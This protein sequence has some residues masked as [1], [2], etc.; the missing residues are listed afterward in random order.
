MR[1][2]AVLFFFSFLLFSTSLLAQPAND[3]CVNAIELTE[4]SGWCSGPRAFSTIGAS[5]SPVA[6]P[7]CFPTTQTSQD[8]WFTFVSQATDINISVIGNIRVNSG[9][10]LNS[11]QLVLY[12]GDCGTLT[13]I[14]CKSDAFN[15]N[16]VETF[17]GP[18]N[19][20]ERY[21][22]R[23]GA[24]ASNVGTF[25]LC[26]N[27]FNN[28]PEP[29]GDCNTGV[30][31]CDKSPFT[32]SFF[33]GTGF[34]PN[35]IQNSSC[36]SPTCLMEESSSTWYK[37]TCRDPGSLTFRL[38]PLNPSDDLDFLVYELPGGLD[39]CNNKQDIRCMAS[40]EV[41]GEPLSVWQP[42]TGPTGLALNDTDITEFCGCD[43]GDNNFL[44]AIDMVAGRS[45]ALVVN[46]FSNTG[47]GFS[48]EFGGTGTFLGPDADFSVTPETV[49]FG[50]E[51]TFIDQSSFVGG[52]VGWTWNFGVG[53]NPGTASGEGPHTVSWDT[54][55]QK[56]VLLSVE[57]DRGCIVTRVIPAVVVDPC[58]EVE[59]AISATADITDVDCP[60]SSSGAIDLTAS[61][62][63]PPHTFLW[64]IGVNTE[65]IIS[66]TPGDYAVT[67][68]ND[69]TCDSVFTFTVD[70]PPPFDIQPIITMPTCAGGQDGGIVLNVQGAT[71]GYQYDWGS[72]FSTDNTLSNL[73]V[74]VYGVT[75][76]DANG[77]TSEVDIPVNELE[78][79]LDSGVP[80][81]INP[82]CDDSFDGSITLN[83]ANGLGP[84][85]Y[86]WGDGNGFV[87]SNVMMGLNAAT[88]NV[89]FRDANGCLGDT[90]ISTVPPP[91]LVVDVDPIDVS[92]FGE[93]DGTATPFVTGGV[94]NYSFLWNDPQGQSDSVAVGLV[95]GNYTVLV[96]DGNG[97]TETGT[98][99]ITEPPE[100]A[101]SVVE[102]IDVLC[103]GEG[104]G[105]ITVEGFG[106]NPD[107]E[108]SIDGVNYQ[109]SPIFPDLPAGNYTL[110]IRDQLGCVDEVDA[111]INQP[112]QLI[113]D[114][115]VD[116]EVELGFT[117]RL[118]AIT[119]PVGRPVS[120]LW[121]PADG[122]SCTDCRNPVAQPTNTT[123]YQVIV[124]DE[125]GCTAT[126]EVTITVIKNRPIYIPNAFTPNGDGVN[127]GFTVY[128]GPAASTIELMR[129]YNRWGA[130]IF[131]GQNLPLNNEQ[132]GWNGVFKGERMNSGVFTYYIIVEFIDSET[133][134]YEGDISLLD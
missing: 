30:I 1:Y 25:Q 40:G 129:I 4:L 54:P 114:A 109:S 72:G 53:A 93:G 85:V 64:S 110:L 68:T 123:T 75:V 6:S 10:S 125:D 100:L 113:V 38:S 55:G 101:I 13:E 134:Q 80:A 102:I 52:L 91:P 18:L 71:P 28:V 118:N 119:L 83:I 124:T 12:T 66:L 9:G 60:D 128:S 89:V 48:I 24:R 105:Q 81:V 17:G 69:A 120:Y 78:L 117:V 21:Y 27:N 70:G 31:L 19:I 51:V 127:D 35:E 104:S 45:Y 43:P 62:N 108:Y 87:N 5:E 32:V 133:V 96:T 33:S 14:E 130:L 59:N 67:I 90:I 115:G 46:N 112:A 98:T 77:C 97:C 86:D 16:V 15:E 42:C 49:C 111:S 132:M 29:S 50:D 116:R 44:Q 94:G 95:P 41:V 131:E 2:T 65:D 23:V 3:E 20:G 76:Q 107:Y 126:D 63:A 82:S 26:L 39:D 103:F 11:P 7:S 79:L 47:L 84:Y 99:S 8:I 122:L 73:P 56:S 121:S 88:F 36:D 106:G 37:W 61:S 74:G 22:I 92:C 58:C 57:T 34:N